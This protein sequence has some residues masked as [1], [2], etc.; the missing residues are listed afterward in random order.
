MNF[1]IISKKCPFY[2]ALRDNSGICRFRYLLYKQQGDDACKKKNCPFAYWIEQ[3]N[4][5]LHVDRQGRLDEEV[6]R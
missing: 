5:P 6:D 3:S 4:T 2:W 1:L